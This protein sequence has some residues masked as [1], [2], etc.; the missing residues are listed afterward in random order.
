MPT[1]NGF[2]LI[3]L[4]VTISIIAI[5]AA[6]GMVSYQ[7]ILKNSRDAKRQADFKVLQS[8]L[9]QYHA[10]QFFYPDS[11]PALTFGSA[12]TNCT[13]N[14]TGCTTTKTYLNI[15]PRDPV[16]SPE[17]AYVPTTIGCDNSGAT[18][19]TSYCLYSKVENY[20]PSVTSC[21]DD[22]TRTLEVTPP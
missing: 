6:I 13:G 11:S 18:R 15:V 17:Y 10:D 1:K 20:T 4:L 22:S 19:C 12:I 3:E 2:T 9:E 14:I 21:A 7:V 16:G 8:A 5:L